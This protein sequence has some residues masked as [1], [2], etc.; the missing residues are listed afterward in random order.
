MSNYY[1]LR[2]RFY[3]LINYKPRITHTRIQ[4]IKKFI[5]ENYSSMRCMKNI[6]QTEPRNAQNQSINS[7]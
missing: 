7:F 3:T 2:Y 5:S 1:H 6:G 4:V